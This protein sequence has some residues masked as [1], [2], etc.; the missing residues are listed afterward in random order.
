[1]NL[2][3]AHKTAF[4]P[5]TVQEYVAFSGNERRALCAFSRV[6][7]KTQR[8][9]MYLV[10]C[11]VEKNP[12]VGENNLIYHASRMHNLRQNNVERAVAALVGHMQLVTAW[13]SSSLRR[14]NQRFFL[15]SAEK[16]DQAQRYKEFL[17]ALHPEFQHLDVDIPALRRS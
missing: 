12:N 17:I 1:M 9:C 3:I 14:R 15:I 11:A 4:K 2:A 8:L 5:S 6:S 10:L 13:S 16:Q 7:F